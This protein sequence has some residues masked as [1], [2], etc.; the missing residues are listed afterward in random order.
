[1]LAARECG[2]VYIGVY[3]KRAKPADRKKSSA[4]SYTLIKSHDSFALY[5]VVFMSPVCLHSSRS[6]AREDNTGAGALCEAP[7]RRCRICGRR[8]PARLGEA[9]TIGTLL[10]SAMADPTPQSFD[11]PI[12]AYTRYD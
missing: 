3:R 9:G 10:Y 1:M 6:R 7:G 4:Y 11:S 5:L 12:I 2:C 8:R